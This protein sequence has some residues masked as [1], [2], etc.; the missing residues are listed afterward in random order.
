MSSG[1]YTV[2]IGYRNNAKQDATVTFTNETGQVLETVNLDDKTETRVTATGTIEVDSETTVYAQYD[3]QN[4]NSETD[5]YY[6][7]LT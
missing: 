7:K 4:K 1:T 5:I 3:A 6:Q 2:E